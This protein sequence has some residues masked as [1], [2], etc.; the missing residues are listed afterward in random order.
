MDVIRLEE[1]V[2]VL[3][4]AGLRSEEVQ[5]IMGQVPSWLERWGIMLLVLVLS[6]LL[7]GACYLSYPETLTGSF[8]FRACKDSGT[9]K[10]VGLALFP[11]QGIGQVC[12]GQKVMVRVDNYPYHK[13]GHL[14]GLVKCVA[15]V[16]DA[17][18]FYQVD[19]VFGQGLRTSEGVELPMCKQLSGIAEIIISERRLIETGWLKKHRVRKLHE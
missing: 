11:A 2:E 14:T 18:G 17:D 15:D 9:E 13:F 16:P 1:D 4:K 10:P 8:L 19:I 7:I 6:V 12:E 5:E 3:D